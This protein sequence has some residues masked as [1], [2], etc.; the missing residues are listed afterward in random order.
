M[1]KTRVERKGTFVAHTGTS[2]NRT[3]FIM[4]ER[5]HDKENNINERKNESSA[6]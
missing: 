5:G 3:A 1:S 4:V 6:H 2:N